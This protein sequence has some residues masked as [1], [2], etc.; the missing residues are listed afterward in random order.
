MFQEIL[1]N[2][3]YKKKVKRDLFFFYRNKKVKDL[4]TKFKTRYTI[5]QVSP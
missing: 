3:F 1:K 4:N 2:S 5:I